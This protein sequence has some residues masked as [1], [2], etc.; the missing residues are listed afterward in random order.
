MV[1][2]WGKLCIFYKILAGEIGV[3]RGLGCGGFWECCLD[4]FLSVFKCNNFGF[5]GVF[6][7]HS[8]ISNTTVLAFIGVF[9]VWHYFR[10]NNY[11]FHQRFCCMFLFQIQQFWLLLV[12][13]LLGVIPSATIL[14]FISVFVA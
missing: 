10:Y 5:L 3:G 14:A 2:F 11:W 6:L 7:L 9:A 8:I 1:P 4:G 13:L 12:F